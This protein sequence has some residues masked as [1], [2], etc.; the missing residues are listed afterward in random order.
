[1]GGYGNAQ[2][3]LGQVLPERRG[4]LFV[5]TRCSEPD[6]ETAMRQLKQNLAELRIERADLVYV[7]SV[8]HDRM[9]IETILSPA[10]VC[11]A[12]E[13]AR[14]EGLTRFIGISGHNRPDRFVRVMEA[15][16]FDVMMTPASVV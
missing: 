1:M 12:L 11:R 15:W 16:D 2:L 13:K 14:R 9:G 10:G 6:G 8:G 7:Q 4:E 3:Y 5:A